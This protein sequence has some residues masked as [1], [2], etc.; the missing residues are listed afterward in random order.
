MAGSWERQIRT[1]RNALEPLLLKT[2]SQL[3]D[4]SFCTFL[5]EV[6]NVVNSRPLTT[7]DICDPTSLEPLTP[8]HLLTMKSK[9]L[10]PPPGKFVRADLCARKRWR[11]VQYLSN[12][13]WN[14]WRKEILHNLQA[15]TKWVSSRRNVKIGDIITFSDDDDTPRNK[16][17]L[18]RVEEVYPSENGRVRKKRLRIADS[19]LDQHGKRTKTVTF[20]DQPVHKLVLLITAD[21]EG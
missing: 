19:E 1:V 13:F 4:D 16:W 10:L 5:V 14:R 3:D 2:G 11:R 9:L 15:R 21:D 18:A 7:E 20:L 8:N 17:K 12:I 6:E